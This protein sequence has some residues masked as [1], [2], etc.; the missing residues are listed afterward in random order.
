MA[1]ANATDPNSD[2]LQT[3]A[4]VALGLGPAPPISPQEAPAAS[5]RGA[6]PQGIP[7]PTGTAL[8]AP[9]DSIGGLAD[10]M[11]AAVARGVAAPIDAAV[12]ADSATTADKFS[13]MFNETGLAYLIEPLFDPDNDEWGFTK[14]FKPAAHWQEVREQYNLDDTDETLEKFAGAQSIG[15]MHYMAT[16]MRQHQDNQQLLSH[17][18]WYALGAGVLDPAMLAVDIATFGLS[19]TFQ[20]GRVASAMAG[21]TALPAYVAATDV[22]GKDVSPSEYLFAAALGSASMALWGGAA[23]ARIASGEANWFGRTRTG[24]QTQGTVQ[25]V[26]NDFLSETDRL[27]VND[28]AVEVLRPIID[29]PVRR[30]DVLS[31]ENAAS[32]YRMYSNELNGLYV[33]YSDAVQAIARSRAGKNWAGALFDF[34][35]KF[36]AARDSL[37]REVAE[38]MISRD[39]YYQRFGTRAPA[40][41][42]SDAERLADIYER[43]MNRA[44]EMAKQAGMKGFEE[45][46]PRPGYFHRS[47]NAAA[48]ARFTG[49]KAG[50]KALRSLFQE[51]ALRGIRGITTED[52]KHI[53]DAIID[54]A[55]ARMED[56]GIDFIGMLG[57]ADTEYLRSML[58][59]AKGLSKQRVD[60]IMGRV[61]QNLDEAGKVKYA[62]DRLPLDMTV[63]T[64][65]NGQRITML[66]FIDTDI[67][68]L[69]ENYN[70]SIAG[71]SALARVGVGGDA[72]SLAGLRRKYAQTLRDLPDDVRQDR[73]LS[74]DGLMGDFTGMIPDANR[75]GTAGQRLKAL[76]DSTML[77]SSGFWQTA[78]Y[79][80]MAHRYGVAETAKEFIKRFP[81]VKNF[82]RNMDDDLYEE[83]RTVVGVDLARD[84]RVHAW[85][86]QHEAHLASRDHLIDRAL[87]AGKQMVPFL[88]GMKYVHA[89]QSRMN[90]NL[91]LNKI[92]RAA[93]GD[94]DAM[95]M[96]AQYGL[97][98]QDAVLNAVRQN[99]S[100]NGKNAR[101]MNWAAWS[102]RDREAAMLV[103]LRMAD[104]AVLF[105]RVGQG[106]GSPLISRSGVGQVL[107]QFRSFVSFAHNKLL[108]GTL[109]NEGVRGLSTLVAYQYPLTA[110]MVL[111]NEAYKGRLDTS[112]AGIQ[113]SML[114]ALGSTAGLGFVGDAFSILGFTGG[115]GGF[116][117]PM[118][119]VFNAAPTI[120]GGFLKV[121]KDGELA[122]GSADIVKGAAMVTPAAMLM[123]GV[124]FALESMKED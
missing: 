5:V 49:D 4:E 115:R 39:L 23:G 100:M 13:A 93:N 89:H 104:D 71:R 53:A 42:H 114:K 95:L 112:D 77:A 30:A 54:R 88:N 47:W 81:G 80:T 109:E 31:N 110:L 98:D 75:L 44:G 83:L 51:S 1:D 103:A 21:A 69:A 102:R 86:R 20:L 38:V 64:T 99:V 45:F 106:A 67:G 28:E 74:F 82:L 68:R 29:D 66:D 118:T 92:V 52:A 7:T 124:G 12:L 25:K 26:L 2:T 43:M 35:G 113:K 16:R 34:D 119:T 56:A 61:E 60:A 107:G 50:R 37:E 27:M 73:L 40:V 79:A 33:E 6:A 117:V 96:L 63:S 85:V 55:A 32:L 18:G 62:K 19:K 94:A 9:T 46:T 14:D 105:G 15:H 108:R 72:E 24:V 3:S 97:R 59:S 116:G 41:V 17:H 84:V 22:A 87:H 76:A 48:I 58:E 90:I 120:G 78:E 8:T 121:V 111:A 122:E 36:L 101:E 57:R 123:P 10:E 91:A 11:A 65:Y 70:H